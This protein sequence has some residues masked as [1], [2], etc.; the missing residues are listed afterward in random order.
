MIGV[1]AFSFGTA[2]LASAGEYESARTLL[3]A[4]K[5]GDALPVLKKLREETPDSIVVAQD[6][7]Q[8][9]LRLNR[10]EEAIA[11]LKEH[12]LERQAEIAGKSFLSK[13][14]FLFYQQGMDWLS[15][16]SYPLACDRLRKAL[17]SDLAHS[18][19]LQRLAQ[20]EILS[21][22]PEQALKLL[23][24]SERLY[25][26]NAESTLWVARALGLR[27][28]HREAIPLF[29]SLTGKLSDPSSEWLAVWW[30]DALI[31]S[32]QHSQAR[33][34]LEEDRKRSPHHLQSTL[35]SL[36][37]RF[38]VAESLNQFRAI[39]QELD[40]LEEQL[41]QRVQEKPKK[42]FAAPLDLFDSSQIQREII[43]LRTELNVRLPAPSPTATPLPRQSPDIQG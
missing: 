3:K 23:E 35:Q 13:G 42:S 15:K 36:R 8:A 9:L 7:A 2:A 5:W 29:A 11:V 18:E 6:Y 43:T 21:A 20:C 16:R 22:N 41:K 34:I 12:R 31:A 24:Q 1:V 27:N 17:D 14:S 33:L 19:I 32:G 30:A 26:K 4:Q 10:R 39:R 38:Q 28:R 40:A 37:L 25:G